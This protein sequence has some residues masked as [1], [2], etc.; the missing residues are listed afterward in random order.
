MHHTLDELLT[1]VYHYYPR[2][3]DPEFRT[4]P[5]YVHLSAARK[6]AGSGPEYEHWRDMLARLRARFPDCKVAN[7]SFHLPTGDCDGGYRRDLTTE[8]GAVVGLYVSFLVPYYVIYERLSGDHELEA[9]VSIPLAEQPYADGIAAETA[10]SYPGY[11]PLPYEVGSV[12][13]PDVAREIGGLGATIYDLLFSPY[14]RLAMN[15]EDRR[16]HAAFMKAYR[17]ME[18]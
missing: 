1:I 12:V 3:D 18:R 9:T 11:E 16:N 7:W 10:V 17:T 2:G 13:V 4:R 5:E 8:Y 6:Q 14:D 15:E